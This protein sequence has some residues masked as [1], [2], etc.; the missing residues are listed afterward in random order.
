MTDSDPTRAGA[1]RTRSPVV[2]GLVLVGAALIGVLVWQSETSSSSTAAS[3]L[4]FFT[5]ARGALGEA[6]GAVPDGVTVFDDEVPAVANL[7]RALLGA[8]REAAADAAEDGVELYVNSGWRS[9]DY[10]EQLLRDAVAEHGSAE[11]AARWVATPD[12]SAHVSGDAID[13]GAADATAW[14]SEHGAAYGLCQIYGNEPWHYEL[15]PEAGELGCPPMYADPT[16]DPRM[17]Q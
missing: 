14:L 17:Q 15:R 5:G 11:E 13:I 10:Q 6:D 3:P 12:A 1:R 2:A 9:A 16:E 7:D 4:D 8:L